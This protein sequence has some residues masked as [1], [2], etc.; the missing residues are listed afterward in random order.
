MEEKKPSPFSQSRQ[1][2]SERKASGIVSLLR[3]IVGNRAFDLVITGVILLQAI[4]LALE[5]TPEIHSFSREGELI[6]ASIFSTIH[7]LVVV[8]FIIEAALRLTAHYP[9]PQSYFKD[10]WNCFDFAIIVLSRHLQV[11][12][13]R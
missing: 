2:P 11:G 13:Q 5:A 1:L 6:E 4:A 9:R 7:T 8:V 3:A 10:G 12:S